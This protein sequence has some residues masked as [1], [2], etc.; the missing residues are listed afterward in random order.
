MSGVQIL[1]GAD[2]EVFMR[3]KDGKFVSAHGAVQGDKANPFKVDKGAVQVDGLALEFNIDPA[4]S[5]DEF[6]TNIQAVMQTL[7]GMVP[8]YE[9]VPD[10]VA[11]FGF[12]YLKEQPPEA[13]ELGC[14]ADFNAWEGGAVNPRPNGDVDFRTGAGHVHIGWTKDQDVNDPEHIEAC[15]ML[16]KQLDVYLGVPSL[17]WDTNNE[18]R[19]LYGKAG[20]FRVKPYGVE[21]RVLSNAWLRSEKLMRWVY[22]ATI[23]ATTDLMNG[24]DKGAIWDQVQRIINN[25]EVNRA[26]PYA[27]ALGLTCPSKLV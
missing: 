15:I 16:V 27:P 21:Y 20:A 23:K 13:L 14:E 11:H 6:V 3:G 10:P 24:V 26:A 7:A 9:L 25:S 8:D 1:V 12:Q 18:R 2:P 4:A 17:M 22:K 19:K 5:E